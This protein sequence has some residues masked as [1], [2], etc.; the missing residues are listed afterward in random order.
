LE[1][2]RLEDEDSGGK[3]GGRRYHISHIFVQGGDF[4]VWYSAQTK[5]YKIAE[6]ANF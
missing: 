3:N 6:I 5:D 1:I 2:V 4:N